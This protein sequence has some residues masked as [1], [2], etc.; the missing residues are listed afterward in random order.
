MG[1]DFWVKVSGIEMPWVREYALILYD[2]FRDREFTAE[3]AQKALV[4]AGK[5]I[6]NIYKLISPLMKIGLLQRV[7]ETRDGKT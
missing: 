2:E 6:D 7:G 4:K 3:D 1:L 5:N